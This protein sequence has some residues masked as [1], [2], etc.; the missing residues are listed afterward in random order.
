[1]R[2]TG[3]FKTL[4]PARHLA[5]EVQRAFWA[6]GALVG[7]CGLATVAALWMH[8]STNPASR[9]SAESEGDLTTG[10]MLVVSPSGKLCS[11]RTIDN[12]TWQIR[13]HGWV[14]CDAA[15]AKANVESHPMG[16]RLDLIRDSFRGKP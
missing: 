12:S 11:Q 10:S 1:M 2:A 15:L 13:E 6:G 9:Y 14:D 7:V 5:G 3:T 16:T 4:K 8:A